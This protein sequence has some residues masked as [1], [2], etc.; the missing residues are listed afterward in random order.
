MGGGSVN[1]SGVAAPAT[2]N[3]IAKN[4]VDAIVKD[5][6]HHI[7]YTAASAPLAF[8]KDQAYRAAA[9]SVEERLIDRWDAT[10]AHFEKEFPKEANYISM[11]FLQGRSLA[12]AVRNIE[13]KETYQ[14]A[15]DKFGQQLEALEEHEGDPG[16]GN[17]GLGRLASCFL[18]S[19]A[20]CNYPGW[21]YGLRYKYGLFRQQIAAN[22][23]QIE[24][25]EAWLDKTNPWEVKR[26]GVSYVVKTHGKVDDKGHWT[27]GEEL[28]VCAYD[29]PIPGYKTN[30]CISLRLWDVQ[31]LSSQLDLMGFNMGKY[32]EA[33]RR[34]TKAGRICAV[35]YPADG[36]YEGKEL[37]LTQQY[38]MCSATVQ[39]ILARFKRR[40]TKSNGKV[41]WQ[42]LPNKVAIQMNDTHP[43]LAA[44]E[45]MR[46]LMDD[47]GMTW[48]AAWALT[49]K[50]V[51]Y[52]NHTV[53]PE[54]LEKWPIKLVDEL[55]PR[56]MQI[57]RRMDR[58]FRDS[59]K[60]GPK[61]TEE[62]F[63][64]RVERMAILDGVDAKTLQ[65]VAEKKKVEKTVVVDA[66]TGKETVTEKTTVIK[67]SPVVRMAHLAVVAA[68]KINGVAALHTDILKAEVLNDFFSIWPQKFQNKTNGVTPRR[69]LAWC[70]PSLSKVLTKKLGSDAWITDLTK[71]EG[72]MKFVDDAELQKEFLNSK[73]ENKRNLVAYLKKETGVDLPVNAMFDVQIKR[74]HEYKRQLLNLLGIVYRY[75]KIKEMTPEQRKQVV[76]KV[77]MFGGKAFITYDQAKRI[78]HLIGAV[79][80]VVNKDPDCKDLLKV[81]FVPNYNV[82]V[83]EQ[84]IPAAELCHQISTA[85]MEASGTSNMKF[86]MNGALTVGTLDGANVEIREAVGAENFF[87]FGAVTDEIPKIREDRRKGLFKPDPRFTE[88]KDYIRSGVFNPG[89]DKDIEHAADCVMGSLEGN[90]GFGIGDYFCVGYDFPGFLDAMA[91]VD[92]TYKDQKKW[93]RMSI[94][95]TAM[96]GKFSSDRTIDQYASEIWTIKREIVPRI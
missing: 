78:V 49:T 92:E 27:A 58:E 70:N 13:M 65:P 50:T 46:I 52:T 34:Q 74:I 18:D 33:T 12:N 44:P 76:P 59:L 7:K 72:L 53:L 83:A 91:K 75:K 42:Q 3:L 14:K 10:Y 20:T 26:E 6:T 94:I 96:S 95:Q 16:L 31:A 37:R 2:A 81:L 77:C 48:E 36:T 32:E 47:E 64:V 43:T 1:A 90:E 40:S 57:I 25:P 56:H 80:N 45:L 68:N 62:D 61:E 4:D 89:K 5:L 38:V 86:Q 15:L 85:G 55:L 67:T 8:G 21:G 69:W 22:G 30:N 93:L 11:E 28:T 17:G 60:K 66:A 19:L 87:L 73:M 35:L 9:A 39:D 29:T 23:A 71:L 63:T 79:S 84:L 88:T 24:M 41:D 82:T 51:N 54:A